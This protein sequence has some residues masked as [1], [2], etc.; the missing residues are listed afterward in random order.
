MLKK[1]FLPL[2][3]AV[4]HISTGQNC[5]QEL[6]PILPEGEHVFKEIQFK[7]KGKKDS[8]VFPENLSYVDHD[9]RIHGVI[10]DDA[11]NAVV[12]NEFNLKKKAGATDM[13]VRATG[14]HYKVVFKGDVVE[15]IPEGNK[16]L[17]P[18]ALNCNTDMLIIGDRKITLKKERVAVGHPD[19]IF[20]SQW[21]GYSWKPVKNEAE[22][23]PLNDFTI[24][25][26]KNS[27]KTYIEIKTTDDIHYRLLSS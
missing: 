25:K 27:G 22:Y 4:F 18:F 12:R 9:G 19:N 23:T 13:V 5:A 11:Y 16:G 1:I 14:V 2:S 21:E 24:A 20:K 10:P 17:K 3:L 6:K 7:H 15:F 26:I 8:R